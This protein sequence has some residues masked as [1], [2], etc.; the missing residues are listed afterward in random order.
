MHTVLMIAF[1][2]PPCS[3]SS[4][5]QRSLSNS[6]HLPKH[7]WRTVVLT[8]TPDAHERVNEQQ[9]PDIPTDV[10][11]ERTRAPDLAKLLSFRGRYWSRLAVPD[12]WGAW[13]WTAVPRGLD[14]IRQ[15]RIDAIWST[16]PIA[17][18]HRIGAALALRSGRPW[19]AD[20]RDPMVETI[21]A[22]GE[23]F[24][25]DPALRAARLR[26]EAEAMQHAARAVF[27]TPSARRI[28]AER[29]TT[30]AANDL[31]VIP[32]GYDEGAFA[33]AG[34]EMTKTALGRRVLLH[35][36]VVYPGPDRD[37]SAL[38]QALRVLR[39]RG[40]IAA[41]NFELRLRDPSN[42]ELF[43][44]MARDARVA[45]LVAIMPALPYRQALAEMLQADGLLLLQGYTSNPAIPAK[46]YEYLR[47]ARPVVGLVHPDGESAA[48]LRD[49]GID[50]CCEL[51]DPAAIALVIERWL[52]ESSA[53]MVRLPTREYVASFSRERLAQR[54]AQQ[55]DAVVAR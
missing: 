53:G 16:Y 29:Y 23:V 35:S 6:I 46:L 43:A 51:T 17:T 55:L 36:G 34:A 7:G 11:V 3:A 37:P 19:V 50:L 10:L 54:L 1:H 2:Y 21:A 26:V 5:L 18:A 40:V 33:K 13:R 41:N 25:R 52:H 48:A 30:R 45:D 31:V 39:E 49:A 8:V 14:L 4:G 47:A 24:P 12:R 44:R 22:T 42:E 27:C 28:A 32:N 15:H 38:F 20:F 9:L